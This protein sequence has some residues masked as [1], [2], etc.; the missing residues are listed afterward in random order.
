MSRVGLVKLLHERPGRVST[1]LYTPQR[2]VKFRGT[3]WID[4]RVG[5]FII[6]RRPAQRGRNG[7]TAHNWLTT[8]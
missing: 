1:N 3:R 6:S 7:Q 5:R 2:L 8:Y 4:Q